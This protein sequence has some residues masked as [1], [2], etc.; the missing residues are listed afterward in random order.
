MR[1]AYRSEQL[2][3]SKIVEIRVHAAGCVSKCGPHVADGDRQ[4]RRGR[5]GVRRRK[6]VA[7]DLRRGRKLSSRVDREGEPGQARSGDWADAYIAGYR[8]M[9]DMQ[10]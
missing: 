2:T 8:H 5:G 9:L 7:G 1:D 6:E 10:Q 4:R 3:G